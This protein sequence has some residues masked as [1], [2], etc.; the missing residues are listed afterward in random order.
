MTANESVPSELLN[1][2]VCPSC[3]SAL[4]DKTTS[5]EC[6]SCRRDY[7]VKEGIP[8]LLPEAPKGR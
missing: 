6:T 5:L 2:L 1:I 4:R 8:S 3:G 7:P